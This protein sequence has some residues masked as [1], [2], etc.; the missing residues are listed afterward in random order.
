MSSET[1]DR[2]V[3]IVAIDRTEASGSV[4]PMATSLAS[5]IP[6]AELHFIHVLE[7]P[8][9]PVGPIVPSMAEELREA[10]TY[11]DEMVKGVAGNFRGR[12]SGHIGVGSPVKHILELASD[13]EADLIVVGTHG[14]N[15]LARMVLGSVSHSVS[16]KA[17]C[18]VLLARPKAYEPTPEIEPPCPQCLE[19]Q[20]DTNGEQLWCPQHAGHHPRGRLHYEMPQSY[21][22]GSM[23][24]RPD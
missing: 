19:T 7:H 21:G 23:L 9:I 10:R 20:R 13:L 8:P 14:K 2:V 11:L 12:I 3:I 1:S 17:H 5:R 16:Q 22:V 6:G 18:P 4:L 15:A 24:I